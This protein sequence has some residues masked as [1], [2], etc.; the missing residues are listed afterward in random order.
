LDI[1]EWL[2]D[3]IA[4]VLKDWLAR[5]AFYLFLA[6]IATEESTRTQEPKEHKNGDIDAGG[7]LTALL[8]NIAGAGLVFSGFLY[9]IMGLFCMKSLKEKSEK[10]NDER[11]QKMLADQNR[12]RV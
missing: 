2:A 9:L 10:E 12:T 8:L 7:I 5:G 4:P 6:V 11:L 3:K 1:S